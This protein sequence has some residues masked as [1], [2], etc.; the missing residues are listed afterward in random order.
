MANFHVFQFFNFNGWNCS[1]PH[2]MHDRNNTKQFL[3][4][5]WLTPFLLS[6]AEESFGATPPESQSFFPHVLACVSI[7][8]LY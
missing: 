3:Y 6:A 2:A 1:S 7:M 4:H 8:V 5:F